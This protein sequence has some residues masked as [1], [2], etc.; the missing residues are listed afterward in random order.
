MFIYTDIEHLKYLL[1]IFM[2]CNVKQTN[3]PKGDYE[4]ILVYIKLY[5]RFQRTDH[6]ITYFEPAKMCYT[7]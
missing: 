3:S 7:S 1:H 2:Y 4:Y 6:Y 5:I